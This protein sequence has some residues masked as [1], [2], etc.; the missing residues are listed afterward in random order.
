MKAVL[1]YCQEVLR[2]KNVDKFQCSLK[3]TRHYEM[4][5]EG[6]EFSL[7]RTTTDNTLDI[8]VIQDCR[9]GRISLN[10]L[11]EAAIREAVELAIELSSTSQQD[12]DYDISP[13]QEPGKFTAGPHEPDTERMYELLKEYSRQVPKL[14]PT[15]RL[16]ETIFV[17]KHVLRMFINSNGVEFKTEQGVYDLSSMFAS[18]DGDKATSFNYTGFTMQDLETSLLKRASLEQLLRQSVEHLEAKPFSGKFVGDLL[19]TPD[20]LREFLYYYTMTLLGDGA[21][22]SGT[23]PFKDKM[24]QEV[25]NS[26]LSISAE[27]T[28]PTMAEGYF[29]TDEGFAAENVTLIDKGVLKSFL[30][31][32]YGSKKTGLAQAKN[33]GGCWV[34]E[35]GEKNLEEMVSQVKRGLL[36]ARFSGGAPSPNGDFSGVAKNS[37]YI[38]N[39]K[40]MYPVTETMISGNLV[41]V[42]KNIQEISSE[43]VDF[44]N[45]LIPYVLTTG[46]TVSGK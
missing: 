16:M 34:V 2:Q 6:T 14:F 29:I 31:S 5:L 26:K 18:K 17:H 11:D 35:P 33:Q 4:N 32:Q 40:I 7:I 38:E 20:C 46:V 25:A 15:I 28:S 24:G 30:L 37:Y 19:F 43:R 42:F 12:L 3:K 8:T 39:G 21:L 13:K 36:I 22:I 41:E 23:S 44:G 27:P 45:G 1:D 10:R 9:K